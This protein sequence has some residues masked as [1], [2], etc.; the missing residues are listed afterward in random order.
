MQF[1]G[2]TLLELAWDY[3]EEGEELPGQLAR[4]LAQQD[5]DTAQAMFRLLERALPS[6]RGRCWSFY[7]KCNTHRCWR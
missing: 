7:A 5:Q 2:P 6:V 1:D 3:W 4:A